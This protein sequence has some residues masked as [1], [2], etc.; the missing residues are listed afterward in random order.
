MTREDVLNFLINNRDF[1]KDKFHI[2]EIGLYGSFSL[3]RQ[4]NNSDI[5]IIIKVP[6]NFKTYHSY[7]E[8]K[9][10]LE[11]KLGKKVDIV[12]KD[13]VNPVIYSRITRDV[14]YV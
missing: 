10:F 4:N 12:Y 14:I 11:D 13:S 2:E 8:L 3:N 9:D 5:D 7:L 1:F 6:K